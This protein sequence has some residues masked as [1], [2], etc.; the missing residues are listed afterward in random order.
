LTAKKLYYSNE[1]KLL[2]F[3]QYHTDITTEVLGTGVRTT[4][5][6]SLKVQRPGDESITTL[7]LHFNG[8][9]FQVNLG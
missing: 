7:F 6:G 2:K 5:P 1:I 4:C 8:H 3:L 9:F